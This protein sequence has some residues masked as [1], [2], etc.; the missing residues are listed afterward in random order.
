MTSQI[1]CANPDFYTIWNYRKEIVLKRQNDLIKKLQDKQVGDEPNS[2][3][4]KQ[5][6]LAIENLFENELQLTANCLMKNP[7][8]YNSWHHRLWTIENHKNP[9]LN[10]EIMLC[11]RFLEMDERNCKFE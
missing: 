7:K 9:N 1:L 5:D 6:E 4:D 8:S 11:N 10:R 2:G 3:D